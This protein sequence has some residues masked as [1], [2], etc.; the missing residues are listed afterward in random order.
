MKQGKL[1]TGFEREIHRL[2]GANSNTKPSVVWCWEEPSCRIPSH[3]ACQIV[4]DPKDCLVRYDQASNDALEVRYQSQDG[5]G[6]CTPMPGYT[7]NFDCMTQTKIATG[8]QRKVHRLNEPEARQQAT[9]W[10]R[11]PKVVNPT[12]G[13]KPFFKRVLSRRRLDSQK[14]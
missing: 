8:F 6:D 9:A 5:R 7:V 1:S 2:V 14:D 11:G 13:H 4:G 10:I 12:S 3:A